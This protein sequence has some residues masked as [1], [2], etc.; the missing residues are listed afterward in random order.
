MA[1]PATE[2][3]WSKKYKAEMKDKMAKADEVLAKSPDNKIAKHIKASTNRSL[4]REEE[5]PEAKTWEFV[6]SAYHAA[7][8]IYMD[9]EASLDEAL[10]E[11]CDA[12]EVCRSMA[13]EKGESGKTKNPR[14]KE[15][16]ENKKL[17]EEIGY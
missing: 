7:R 9:G 16:K 5:K 2:S 3:A 12:L 1:V 10:K 8:D 4:N 11:L 14:G 6:E 15:A 17:A 13:T